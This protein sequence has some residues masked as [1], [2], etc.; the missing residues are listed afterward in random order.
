MKHI[1]TLLTATLLSLILFAPA[2]SHYKLGTAGQL[3]FRTLYIPPI[4]NLSLAPQVTAL[5]TKQ[6]IFSLQRA[7]EIKIVQSQ[8]E[9]DATLEIMVVDFQQNVAAT[10][11]SDTVLGESFDLILEAYMSIRNNYTGNYYL[12]NHAVIANKQ[13]FVTG[14]YQPALYEIMP[15]L[16]QDL[17]DQIRD[18]VITVW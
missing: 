5:I 16:T 10:Q 17:A 11:A 3:P 8:K 4:E 7:Q 6:L 13:A 1:P 2:C 15:V 14:G 12:R 9:A 18:E